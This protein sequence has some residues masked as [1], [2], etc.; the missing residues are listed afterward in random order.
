MPEPAQRLLG[1]R[2]TLAL[3][4]DEVARARAAALG[5]IAGLP[6]GRAND[7]AAG[8][9][10]LRTARRGPRRG[11]GPGQLLRC[12]PGGGDRADHAGG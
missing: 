10:G 8:S 9:A 1:Y 4:P 3:R 5:E 2:I 12:E 6:R 11:R 7:P